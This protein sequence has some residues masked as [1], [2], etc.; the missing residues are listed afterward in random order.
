[1]LMI[2]NSWD[3][4]GHEWTLPRCSLPGW[5]QRAR[6]DP[7]E[8]WTE[9]VLSHFHSHDCFNAIYL[10]KMYHI[11]SQSLWLTWLLPLMGWMRKLKP[12][13]RPLTWKKKW[14]DLVSLL[15]EMHV[16]ADEWFLRMIERWVHV[17]VPEVDSNAQLL[18]PPPPINPLDTN[19]PLLTVS[20][21]FF[22]GAIAAKGDRLFFEMLILAYSVLPGFIKLDGS[23]FWRITA[24]IVVYVWI[25]RAGQ[26]VADLDM[27]APGDEGWGEDA[28]LHLDEGIYCSIL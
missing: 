2:C 20:K 4:K 18:Q 6:A 1:M 12:W 15:T 5:R 27:D 28:E 10:M 21:G 11:H 7:E 14:Y 22:E 16:F 23:N 19:W 25:G 9:W 17:Q 13:R 26:M 3:K 8:L 24:W